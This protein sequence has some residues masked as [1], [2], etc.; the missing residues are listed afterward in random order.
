[1]EQGKFK[2]CGEYEA[3]VKEG[4]LRCITKT[5]KRVVKKLTN[6]ENS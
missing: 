5:F 1:M 2:W 4:M 6:V 3:I